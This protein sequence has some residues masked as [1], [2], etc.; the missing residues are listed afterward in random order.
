MNVTALVATPSHVKWDTK[1][2]SSPRN[3][4]FAPGHKGGKDGNLPLIARL[5]NRVHRIGKREFAVGIVGMRA[6]VNT[7]CNCVTLV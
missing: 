4:C 6:I 2:D 1:F 3:I 5:S 7:K